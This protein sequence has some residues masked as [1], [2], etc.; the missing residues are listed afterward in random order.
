MMDKEV[1]KALL[2]SVTTGMAKRI[3]SNADSAHNALTLQRKKSA[4]SAEILVVTL[5]SSVLLK[6]VKMSLQLKRLGNFAG[7]ITFLVA[8]LAP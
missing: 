2:S 1:L 5:Q 8:P 4:R 7:S 6:K 3:V